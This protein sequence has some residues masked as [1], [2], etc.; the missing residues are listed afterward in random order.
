LILAVATLFL[1]VQGTE[2]VAKNK[3]RMVDPH[4]KRGYFKIGWRW[5]QQALF[6]GW[7]IVQHLFLSSDPDPEP[8][9]PRNS[10]QRIS[11][12]QLIV[13]ESYLNLS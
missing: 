10:F 12:N 1:V 2:V 3:R 5:I 6:K 9:E 8:I 11:R 13:F 4:W 7:R